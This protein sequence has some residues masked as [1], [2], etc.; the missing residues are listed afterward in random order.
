MYI[1]SEK[2][3][4]E[5]IGRRTTENWIFFPNATAR[6]RSTET[7]SHKMVPVYVFTG[8]TEPQLW[9]KHPKLP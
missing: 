1:K 8:V 3:E 6:R 7:T 9:R 4:E 5:E 2:Q